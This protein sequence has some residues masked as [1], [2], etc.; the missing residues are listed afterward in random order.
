MR[1]AL[2]ALCLVGLC[3]CARLPARLPEPQAADPRVDIFVIRRGWHV[4]V[5]FAAADLAPPLAS[6]AAYFPGARYLVFGFSDRRYL[7]AKARDSGGSLA[8][9][10]PGPGL[11][12]ATGLR[13]TPPAAFGAGHVLALPVSAVQAQAAQRFVWNSIAQHPAV[14]S[15]YAEGPYPGS[16]FF[17]AAEHYDAFDTCNTWAARA[18]A[19]AGLAIRTR[20]VV[21]AGQIWSQVRHL[22]GAP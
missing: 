10:W 9:L 16:L 19:A 18:L 22:A 2:A 15:P 20:G 21:F 6:L 3:A 17:A 4:D 5:G 8:A 13:A 7:L 14:V 1:R 11:I 12:L